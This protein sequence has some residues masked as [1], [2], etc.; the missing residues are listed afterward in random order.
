[1][2]IKSSALS[3]SAFC[4]GDDKTL[5]LTTQTMIRAVVQKEIIKRHIR[6]EQI[7]SVEDELVSLLD[8]KGAKFENYIQQ[9]ISI[10]MWNKR[11]SRYL[12][13]FD[14]EMAG[15]DLIL[16][17]S[18][19]EDDSVTLPIGED[20]EIEVIP[21]F[22]YAYIDG[23]DIYITKIST[24]RIPSGGPLSKST[25]KRNRSDAYVLTQ[26]AK[27]KYPGKN[28]IIEWDYLGDASSSQESQ[29]MRDN[30]PY[31][32]RNAKISQNEMTP[33]TLKKLEATLKE[34]I[35][36]GSTQN[37]SP[38]DC[39]TCAREQLCHFIEP[40]TPSQLEARDRGLMQVRLSQDQ[41]DVVDFE[42]GKARV[43]AGAGV[44]KTLV[45]SFRTC[46][47]IR[48]G[49]DPRKICLLTFTKN[50][51]LEMKQRVVRLLAG[52]EGILTD[53][54]LITCTT[55]NSFCQQIIED[56]FQDLGYRQPPR[57]VPEEVNSGIINR[58]L[59]TYDRIPE[60]NYGFTGKLNRWQK[61]ALS[62]AKKVFSDIKKN[63]WTIAN[64]GLDSIYSPQSI[65]MI[66]QMYNDYMA[67]M[68]NRC[69]IDYDD[70]ELL[71]FKLLEIKPDIFNEYG[72]EH[73]I[74][75]EN[76]DTSRREVDI[77][78]KMID[79]NSFKSFMAVGDDAQTV[80]GF[81][82][83]DDYNRNSIEC[84]INFEDY[85][86]LFQDFTL[87]ENHRSSR[88][89]IN[90][91]N[92]VNE[93]I[94]DR[95]DKNLIATKDAGA[96]VD[97]HG[98]YSAKSEHKWI[99]ED[100]KRQ[101]EE[102]G[103][104]PA[105][106]AVLASDRYELESIAS[107]CTKIGVPT[108]LM[109]PIPFKD[110]PRVKA[111]QDFYDSYVHGT[112]RGLINYENVMQHGG[113]KNATSDELDEVIGRY[114]AQ[115]NSEPISFDNFVELANKLDLEQKDECFQE[116]LTKIEYCR[117]ERNPMKALEEFFDDFDKYGDASMYKREGQYE[118]NVSL[119]T[120]H[121]SKGL[122]WDTTYLTLS[123][124]DNKK[125]HQFPSKYESEMNDV[126][127]KWFVGGSRAKEKLIVTGQY[128]LFH[129]LKEGVILNNY[130]KKSYELLDKV[131]GYNSMAFYE[132]QRLD[133]LEEQREREENTI[134]R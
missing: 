25:G 84:F 29:Y 134:E 60:W 95:L 114:K 22:D 31:E 12:D 7:P 49:Y 26:W 87:S 35:E 104:D 45:I 79:A 47:L 96:P 62:S 38:E 46:E 56:H 119:I 98:F 58:V 126:A 77:L 27:H 105:D 36:D 65:A 20:R 39:A 110:N 66:F 131:Y 4:H 55:I 107:E 88:N 99:A 92:K 68:K 33:D 116:F 19:S 18:L 78:N 132:Q 34:Q 11:I 111:L 100:I 101:I 130:V 115:L 53:P 73:I 8:A 1:M 94:T 133:K 120:V 40:P 32:F 85:Y 69:F 109:N 83:E 112:T 123:K 51:A 14:R 23:N 42:E 106:I 86:G 118:S 63:N 97:M 5:T 80:M 59:S 54:S 72:F 30:R 2:A 13:Y 127:R 117:T 50:G 43:I 70:Q 121:S 90:Y 15:K 21:S 16:E 37:C 108:I 102:E 41:K 48:K 91:A 125:Y 57:I 64:N 122:E 93:T 24:G 82:F 124:F 74:V 17:E 10:D 67:Q 28:V 113:L 81:R 76:Q 3:S 75:D 9:Q 44:G 61:T 103:K 89:I 128:V 52:Q 6:G 71:I 129:S